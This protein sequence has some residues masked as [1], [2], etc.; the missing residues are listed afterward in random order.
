MK[1]GGK[2]SAGVSAF[3]YDMRVGYKFKVFKPFSVKGYAVIDPKNFD[4]EM[5]EEVDYTP[6]ILNL[7]PDYILIPP[8]SF[9]LA[10]SM[11]VF[12][13][14]RD[15]LAVVLGKS[16][17]A[18]CGLVVNCTPMEPEWRG[19][20]TIELS[21]TTPLPMKVYCG[22]GIAQALFFRSDEKFQALKEGMFTLLDLL[23]D[24]QTKH[25][26]MVSVGDIEGNL[27]KL[28]ASASC[29]RSYADKAG[30]YLDQT[31]VTLPKV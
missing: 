25:G 28:F 15:T 31:E 19:V 20:L 30:K 21:N 23:Q 14:P 18:R 2:I 6:T 1:E 5:L 9:V 10:E 7:Q 8:H 26:S 22:E 17:Y 16:T 11:E 4:T 12:N 29:E 13:I 27:K 24:Q 3:G